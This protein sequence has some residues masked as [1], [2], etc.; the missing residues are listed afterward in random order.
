VSFGHNL[1]DEA[2]QTQ[3]VTV[4][5]KEAMSLRE[6]LLR[7]AAEANLNVSIIYK[8]LPEGG[9][10]KN[11]KIGSTMLIVIPVAEPSK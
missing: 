10:E 5:I 8:A 9:G 11:R 3:P 4:N 7:V 1:T 6:L 2:L